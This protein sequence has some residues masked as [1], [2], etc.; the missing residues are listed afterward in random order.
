MTNVCERRDNH[1]DNRKVA[2][3]SSDSENQKLTPATNSKSKTKNPYIHPYKRQKPVKPALTAASATPSAATDPSDRTG[4][5]NCNVT[6]SNDTATSP[7]PA[8][9][10]TQTSDY[11]FEPTPLGP[12]DDNEVVDLS[13]DNIGPYNQK[14]DDVYGDHLHAY[15]GTHLNGGICDD[16]FWQT[17]FEQIMELP[18]QMFT[19]PN[20]AIV[21]RIITINSSLFDDIVARKCNG[22]KLLVF[23]S[24]IL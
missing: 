11:P 12:R 3:T 19:V 21:K 16:P 9:V 14:L 5:N 20:N 15:P 24:V 22:E 13:G 6:P 1:S 23:L 2:A 4:N 10:A 17:S 7:S 18:Q 8:P